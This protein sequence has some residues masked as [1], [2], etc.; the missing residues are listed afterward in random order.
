[1]SGQVNELV[2]FIAYIAMKDTSW[3]I[4]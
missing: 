1:M 3:F 4:F 2:I